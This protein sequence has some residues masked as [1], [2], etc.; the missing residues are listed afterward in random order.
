[1]K[2]NILF[3]SASLGLGGSEK[4]MTEMIKRI[5]LE[6]YNVT[7]LAL[8]KVKT[9]IKFDKRIK[10]ING[11]PF[12]EQLNLPMKSAITYGIKEKNI[13]YLFF[14]IKYWISTKKGEKHISEYFWKNLSRMILPYNEEY[15]VAIGYGQGYATYF[16][17]DKVSSVHKKILWVNTDLE[18]ANYNIKFL[19]RFYKS[20]N[21]IV[22]DS[23]NGKKN[24]ERLFPDCI[25]KITCFP[26]MLDTK[27]I[28]D[29][30]K[31]ENLHL[32][33]KQTK[34]LTV[35]RLVEA[36]AI[37]FVVEAA[38]VLK[39]KGYKFKW[40]VVGDGNERKQISQMIYD[41]HLENTVILV[42]AK[43]NP[44]P[45]FL[46]CDIYVQ[47]S[48]YEGSCMTISEALV[49]D[50]PVV[51]TNFPAAYEKIEDGVN[52]I[53]CKMDAVSI[54]RGIEKLLQDA[55]LRGKIIK[56]I[57]NRKNTVNSQIEQF[58]KLL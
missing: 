15:D 27:L 53:I 28:Q 3:I 51:T 34:I 2:K 49:F 7:V 29:M 37:H 47:T 13:K 12:F 44:Y 18:R 41:S 36:K 4:C 21:L 32:D 5:D 40:Y 30:A 54:S 26:N 46:M 8:I 9:E 6:K 50:K 25:G 48:I 10:V 31:R 58:Y 1:M 16:C 38:L 23:E 56:A 45:W 22:T 14:K 33:E 57:E 52:G 17:I 42:G 11:Y 39:N 24:Q 19:S 20:A 55:L 35:G 43:Q